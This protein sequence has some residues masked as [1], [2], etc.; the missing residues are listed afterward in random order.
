MRVKDDKKQEALFR[1]IIKLVNE[2]GFVASSVSKIAQEAGVSS[3]TLYI[4]FKNKE[5]L[6]ISTDAEIKAG[7][8]SPR[9]SGLVK[10]NLCMIFCAEFGEN[11]GDFR[12]QSSLPTL[13]TVN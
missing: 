11:K 6:L 13:H 12:Y 9:L 4:Y 7:M 2:I 8:E 5:D 1:V 3:V 10:P